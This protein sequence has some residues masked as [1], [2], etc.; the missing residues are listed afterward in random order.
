MRHGD[1]LQDVG[2]NAKL[3]N[4]IAAFTLLEPPLGVE[5]RDLTVTLGGDVAFEI[6]SVG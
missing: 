5:M 4:L 2:T 1:R 6:A 3:N